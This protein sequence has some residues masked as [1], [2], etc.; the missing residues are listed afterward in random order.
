MIARINPLLSPRCKVH[1]SPGNRG[2]WSHCPRTYGTSWNTTS[3]LDDVTCRICLRA[4]AR[5]GLRPREEFPDVPTFE[6]RPEGRF[7]CQSGGWGCYLVF[8]CPVCGHE[9]NHGG[10]YDRPGEGD[11]HRVSHCGCWEGGYYIREVRSTAAS[12][13]S[14]TDRD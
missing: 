4:I 6:V 8:R 9:N 12:I 14:A 3:R 13:D 5:L 10:S 7:R 1:Y 11:G 2:Y